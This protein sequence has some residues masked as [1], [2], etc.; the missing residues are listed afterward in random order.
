MQLQYLWGAAKWQQRRWPLF[1]TVFTSVTCSRLLKHPIFH[2]TNKYVSRHWV[3]PKFMQVRICLFQ[4]KPIDHVGYPFFGQHNFYSMHREFV[5]VVRRIPISLKNGFQ[6]VTTAEADLSAVVA[7]RQEQFGVH[8]SYGHPS[9]ANRWESHIPSRCS[10][11]IRWPPWA[12]FIDALTA[13]SQWCPCPGQKNSES[14]TPA[15]LSP[16]EVGPQPRIKL[17]TNLTRV[18]YQL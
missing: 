3:P 4:T 6:R 2:S 13:K 1:F 8:R 16:Y 7:P 5:H 15:V 18:N 12:A 14:D 10:Q 17:V 11:R 9:A